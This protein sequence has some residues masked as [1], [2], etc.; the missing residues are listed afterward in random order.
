MKDLRAEAERGGE[1]KG[2]GGGGGEWSD[3]VEEKEKGVRRMLYTQ[4]SLGTHRR[5][6][7]VSGVEGGNEGEVSGG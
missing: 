2:G 5:S 6:G 7:G 1:E 4:R 3:W